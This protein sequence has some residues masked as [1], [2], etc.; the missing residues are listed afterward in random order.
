MREK[1][2]RNWARIAASHPWRVII[3][4]LVITVLAAISTSRLRMDMRWSDLLPMNDPKARE[5]DE[6]ITEYKSASTF[7]VVVRGEEQ[8]IKRF[9]DAIAPEI[10]QLDQYFT[11]V[12]YKL[13]KE[14]LSNHA[15]MLAEKE[16]L[17][18]TANMFRDLDL[19]PLLKSINDNFEE[20]YVGDEEALSTKEKENE[21]VRTLDGFHSWLKAMDTFI[22][23]PQSANSAIADSAVERFLYGDPSSPRISASCS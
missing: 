9:S 15:L 20:E 10:L 8:Q 13:D 6:I 5:F 3:M 1:L 4:V 22:T 7:L 14:F 23:N 21:A 12:D 19:I 17:E 16:D 18:T 11:R 2:L